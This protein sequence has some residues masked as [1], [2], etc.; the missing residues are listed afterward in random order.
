MLHVIN[1]SHHFCPVN[2]VHAIDGSTI[3]KYKLKKAIHLQ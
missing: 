2:Y 1:S 3:Q